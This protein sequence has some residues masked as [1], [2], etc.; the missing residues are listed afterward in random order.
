MDFEKQAKAIANQFLNANWI[1]GGIISAENSAQARRPLERLVFDIQALAN[2]SYAQG[3]EDA[4]NCAK[5]LSGWGNGKR[6]SHEHAEHI[7]KCIRS[8]NKEEK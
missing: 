2:Q 7:E 6:A 8:L 3:I 4:A 5:H 1:D